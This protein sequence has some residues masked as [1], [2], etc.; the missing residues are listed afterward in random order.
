MAN[1]RDRVNN[2]PDEEA[3]VRFGSL[4]LATL[5]SLSITASSW[6]QGQFGWMPPAE[7]LHSRAVCVEKALS[8]RLSLRDTIKFVPASREQNVPQRL[9]NE[10]FATI[11]GHVNVIYFVRLNEDAVNEFKSE[12]RRNRGRFFT[13]FGALHIRRLAIAEAD[14]AGMQEVFVLAHLDRAN[15]YRNSEGLFKHFFVD[16]VYGNV[17]QYMLQEHLDG[18]CE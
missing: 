3:A 10:Q 15:P 6:A 5:F 12:I 7:Q 17:A 16:V 11:G 14:S 8:A 18:S 2:P 1:S 9:R 4:G 13:S